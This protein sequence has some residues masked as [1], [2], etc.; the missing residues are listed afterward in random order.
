[1]GDGPDDYYPDEW[2][3]GGFASDDYED[4]DDDDYD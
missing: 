1:L 3:E 4:R 2:D